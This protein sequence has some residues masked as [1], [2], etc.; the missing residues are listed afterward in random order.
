MS[1]ISFNVGEVIWGKIR[2][3]SWWPAVITGT[4]DDNREKKYSV[5]FIGD[6]SHAL[7]TKKNK[8]PAPNGCR[9]L[10][11]ELCNVHFHLKFHNKHLLLAFVP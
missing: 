6:N 9:N 5:S 4:D 1:N 10:F 11:I 3:Y 7:L 2:G 8:Y